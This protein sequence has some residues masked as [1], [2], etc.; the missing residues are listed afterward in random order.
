MIMTWVWMSVARKEKKQTNWRAVRLARNRET[1][2]NHTTS[3][4]LFC[5]L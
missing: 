3:C 2:R 1:G 5:V 4:A